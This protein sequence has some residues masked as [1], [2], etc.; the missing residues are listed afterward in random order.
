M[1]S[2]Q[3]IRR[4]LT[5]FDSTRTGN[6]FTDVLVIG[7]GVAGLSAAAEAARYGD[8][9][10]IAKAGIEN[11]ATYRAQGG[12]GGCIQQGRFPATACR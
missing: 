12:G 1:D 2:K 6:V 3:Y 10:L 4:Y 5:N 8:V 7:R 11:T 9:V